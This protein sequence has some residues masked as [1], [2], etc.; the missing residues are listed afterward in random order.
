MLIVELDG[1]PQALDDQLERCGNAMDA[2]GALE[3]LVASHSGERERLW[4]A[5]RELSRSLRKVAAFKLAEDVVVARS[6]IPALI[7]SCS[8]ISERHGVRM[9]SYG[10]AGDG[11]IH[12]NFLWND[13]SEKPAVDAA[14]DALFHRVIELGGTLSGEHGIGILKAPYLAL[15]QS[16]Q[17]IALQERIKDVFDPRGILNPG[18]IF[19]AQHRRFH[20]PC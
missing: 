10:H 16:P 7:D 3:V 1:E 4:S 14:V 13:D 18:K 11:N 8:A 6:K 5:R 12:V 2:A 17:L 15:E 19:P 20:G 9:P